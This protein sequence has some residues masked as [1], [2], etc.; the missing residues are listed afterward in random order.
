M[1]LIMYAMIYLCI[2]KSIT[3]MYLKVTEVKA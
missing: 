2:K 3:F 1:D